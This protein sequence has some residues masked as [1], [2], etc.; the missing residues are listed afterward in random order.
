MDER[1]RDSMIAYLRHRMDEFGIRPDDLAAAIASEETEQKEA[2]YRSATGNTW[3]GEGEMPQW[4]KQA[5]S[6]G[7]SIEHFELSSKAARTVQS[8]RAGVDWRDDPF[9]GTPLARGQRQ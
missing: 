4:L 9:A 1:K 5:T 3:S 7:Q 2:R 8:A 6:A